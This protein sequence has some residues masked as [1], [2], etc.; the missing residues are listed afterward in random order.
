MRYTGGKSC[1]TSLL[2]AAV[3]EPG[4]EAADCPV[5]TEAPPLPTHNNFG[6]PIVSHVL[7]SQKIMMQHQ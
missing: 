5:S 6:L 7:L 3:F 1:R 4:L 2:G